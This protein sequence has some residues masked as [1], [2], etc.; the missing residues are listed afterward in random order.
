MKRFI[1]FLFL[2]LLSAG[3]LKAG[4]IWEGNAAI[5]RK[6][7]FDSEGLFAASN[8]FPKNSEILVENIQN[9][10]QVK[11]TVLQ[12]IQ[13]E[14]NIFL[15]LSEQAALE[16][17]ISSSEVIRVKA[18]MLN[19]LGIDLSSIP[20]DLPYN[21]DPD[22]DPA[23]GISDFEDETA[24]EDEV[25]VEIAELTVSESESEREPV[26]EPAEAEESSLSPEEQ[27][28]QELASRTPQKQLFM[29]PREDERFVLG[30]VETTPKEEPSEPEPIEEERPSHVSMVTPREEGEELATD[31]PD[32]NEKPSIEGESY[33]RPPGET[34][35]AVALAEP[36]LPASKEPVTTTEPDRLVITLEPSEPQ[37]PPSEEEAIATGEPEEIPP[38]TAESFPLVEKLESKSYFLQLGA[39]STRSRAEK[40]V[41]DLSPTYTVSVLPSSIASRTIFRVLIGPLNVDESGT[42]LY[43]FKSRGFKDAFIRFVD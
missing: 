39:Y 41:R 29:P 32:V 35:K 43:R 42:L 10:K 24:E 6:G 34:V 18:S 17:G 26:E 20:D 40:L 4:E 12:R 14:S 21:P 30:T 33:P 27:R 36:D 15:L 22:I 8:S 7:E 37:P 19:S 23:A 31:L 3:V 38:V 2:F 5:I 11:V 13:G 1:Y 16:I 28:L 9:G 25:P